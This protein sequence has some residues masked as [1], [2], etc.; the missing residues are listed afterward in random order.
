VAD[1]GAAARDDY[2][3]FE[4]LAHRMADAAGEVQRRYFRTPVAVETKPDQSPV[5]AA[6]RESEAAIRDLI[7]RHHPDHGVYGEEHGRERVDAEFVWCVDPIDGTKSFITGRPLFGT[8]IALVHAGRPVLGIIDQSVLRERWVGIAGEGAWWNGR[9]IR[10][11]PCP[12]L[13][14]ATLFATSPRM[15]AT[16]AERAAF[17]AVEAAVRLPMYGG[18]CYAYGLLAAGFADL[19]VEASLEPYDYMALVPVIEGAGGR[20]TDWRGGALG[21]ASAGQAVAAGD[22]RVHAEALA[23]L[24]AGARMTEK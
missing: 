13:A 8:L 4:G 24:E 7:A 1:D 22:G 15:F 21:F 11:R 16:E 6:D 20:I 9:P 14:E 3:A 2:R 18:D 10:T 19:C 12:S 5:T 23:A 17:G